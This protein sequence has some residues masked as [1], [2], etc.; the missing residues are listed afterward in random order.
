MTKEELIIKLKREN[1][2]LLEENVRLKKENL[3]LFKKDN[4]NL[5]FISLLKNNLMG[6]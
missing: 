3:Q 4:R 1:I 6:K 5:S 2:E